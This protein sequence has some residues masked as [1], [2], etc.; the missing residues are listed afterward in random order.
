MPIIAQNKDL[1][2][3]I[4][5]MQAHC[6]PDAVYLCDGSDAEFQ[7]IS[8]QMVEAGSLIRL[9]PDLRPNSF[10]ARSDP[11]DVAR[12]EH[13]TF[14]CTTTKD[15]AGPTNNWAEPAAMR[16]ELDAL[17]RGAMAGRT[18]YVIPFCMGPMGSDHAL[19]GVQITDSPY[20]VISMKLMAQIG[21]PVLD[22]LGEGE[23]TRCLHSVGA[24]LAPGQ[25]DV[26]WPCNADHKYIVSFQDDGSITSFG[27]GYGG[28]ALLGKKCLSLRT[29]SY[30][31]RNE[32]WLA[33]H[34]LIVGL[35]DPAGE[36][37]YVAGAFPSAC[38]KT[39]FAMMLPPEGMEGYTVKTIGDDIAWIR[40][41]ADGRLWAVN[42]EDGFFGV[43][44]GTNG[45]T[46]PNIMRALTRDV[47][48]TN[49]ALTPEGDIW[50]EGLTDAPPARLTDWQG[51]DW[52]PEAGRPA[53]HP[54]ARFTVSQASAPSMDPARADLQGVPISAFIFG[55]RLSHTYP[56]VF[57]SR[58]WSE[59]V[60]WAATL[61]SEA[62]A[63]AEGQT[64]R[65]DPFAMLPFCGYNMAEY[66]QHWLDLG[67]G[68]AN[69]PAIFR[70]NWFRR[71]AERKFIWPGFGQNLR[72]L[73]WIVDRVKGR[74]GA[75][76]AVIG[77]VPG[78]GDLDWTGFDYGRDRFKALMALDAEE[79]A[80]EVADHRNLF[81]EFGDRLPPAL[82]EV[83]RRLS[84]SLT[85]GQTGDHTRSTARQVAVG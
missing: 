25:A 50:W 73:K 20:V 49:C 57:Q 85:P 19:I 17:F 16:A 5:E 23:F 18:M 21:T 42:P 72:A 11:A 31:A 30:R 74:A 68:L 8:S 9:N 10:L 80:R 81:A 66:W 48:F 70:V 24:P 51:R 35:E 84:E 33:E 37:T 76:E 15:E 4:E 29:A 69:P 1:N 26:P 12:L 46:N 28:N 52:T 45:K 44:P 54:N 79:L 3:W 78:H 40:P 67:Q 6:R 71:D 38:G 2:A 62:T 32:G 63:A 60:Y 65:R 22:L 47:I 77:A 34:M 27:S 43:A 39:N 36:T 7:R 64:T 83:H 56:L 59:G 82:D 53:A 13:R 55:G 75:E 58:D 41:G 14:V 61:G